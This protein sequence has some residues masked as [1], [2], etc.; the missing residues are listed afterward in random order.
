MY[1]DIGVDDVS[2]KILLHLLYDDVVCLAHSHFR[3]NHRACCNIFML[4]TNSCNV[5][6]VLCRFTRNKRHRCQ[7]LYKVKCLK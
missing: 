6:L 3:F 5:E 1:E 7:Y 2:M 4:N